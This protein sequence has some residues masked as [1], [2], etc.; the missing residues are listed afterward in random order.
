M[1]KDEDSQLNQAT[2][3][4]LCFQVWNKG[5]FEFK[6]YF[7]PRAQPLCLYQTCSMNSYTGVSKFISFRRDTNNIF[8]FRKLVRKHKMSKCTCKYFFIFSIFS[9]MY[10]QRFICTVSRT[11]FLGYPC[12]F[13]KV[14]TIRHESL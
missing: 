12:F 13:H 9:N 11:E 1:R 7:S 2:K 14:I 8:L 6:F 4:T 5:W 3:H 10:L